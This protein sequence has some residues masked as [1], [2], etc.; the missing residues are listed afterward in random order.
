MAGLAGDGPP[1]PLSELDSFKADEDLKIKISSF[2]SYIKQKADLNSPSKTE[3]VFQEFASRFYHQSFAIVDLLP[4]EI[5]ISPL[6]E[7]F[8][9]SFI[10]AFKGGEGAFDY[11]NVAQRVVEP[12]FARG[13]PNPLSLIRESESGQYFA[14]EGG[15]IKAQNVG[16]IFLA[17]AAA[18]TAESYH[19]FCDGLK[20]MTVPA[21]RA[22]KRACFFGFNRLKG[23]GRFAGG[24]KKLPFFFR[25]RES[26]D[27]RHDGLF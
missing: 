27:H 8:Y 6:D 20:I 15:S 14:V 3:R 19:L 12:S 24:R 23:K 7:N 13:Q 9:C 1:A 16:R 26:A 2:C 22:E 4:K 25:E 10:F 21:W 11:Y 5:L 17:R 18:E